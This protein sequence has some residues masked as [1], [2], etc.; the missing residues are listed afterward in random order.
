MRVRWPAPP[1]QDQRDARSVDYGRVCII[2]SV[3]CTGLQFLA[4]SSTVHAANI[5]CPQARWPQ[6]PSDPQPNP[7]PPP[8][9]PPPRQ[10]PR[11]PRPPP[12]PPPPPRPPGPRRPS[13]RSASSP[14]QRDGRVSRLRAGVCH[15]FSAVRCPAP[16]HGRCRTNKMP[17][18]VDQGMVG[19]SLR[20]GAPTIDI[21]GH[22]PR[23]KHGL[24][25]ARW[26]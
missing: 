11:P 13:G 5:D 18:Y 3:R 22:S 23:G 6:S 26:A 1:H 14:D 16:P 12:P 9:P 4:Q 17:C 8:S 21:L 25:Q 24:P 2:S 7:P 19:S 20:C 10:T 15:L